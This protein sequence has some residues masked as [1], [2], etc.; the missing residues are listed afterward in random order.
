MRRKDFMQFFV[1]T[2]KKKIGYYFS[3][4]FRDESTDVRL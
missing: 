4:F 2:T 1:D 3:F